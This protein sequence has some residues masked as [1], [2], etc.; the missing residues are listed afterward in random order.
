MWSHRLVQ[1][2]SYD[3]SGLDAQHLLRIE[4]YGGH[5]NGLHL[6]IRTHPNMEVTNIS[7]V[8]AFA[9]S[10]DYPHPYR[11]SYPAAGT[12]SLQLDRDPG[13]TFVSIAVVGEAVTCG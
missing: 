9:P 6:A 12:R 2:K 3:H 10:A 7:L 4:A 1:A 11:A 13:D 5:P 8:E